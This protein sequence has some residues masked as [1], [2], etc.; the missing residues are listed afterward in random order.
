M[1]NF[2][3]LILSGYINK[4]KQFDRLSVTAICHGEALEPLQIAV[5]KKL[6]L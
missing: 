2:K 6:N 1:E 3:R 5:Y 4:H